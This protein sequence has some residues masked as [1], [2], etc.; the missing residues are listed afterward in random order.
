MYSKQHVTLNKQPIDRKNKRTHKKYKDEAIIKQLKKLE[1]IIK[2]A[3]TTKTNSKKRRSFKPTPGSRRDLCIKTE[4]VPSGHTPSFSLLLCYH[5]Y[6][7]GGG[8]IYV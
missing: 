3:H 8:G 1:N 4:V 5:V 6:C 2:H 7:V